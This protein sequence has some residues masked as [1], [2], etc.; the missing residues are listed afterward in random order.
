VRDG[1]AECLDHRGLTDAAFEVQDG[2]GK[3]APHG[4][5]NAIP[6]AEFVCRVFTRTEID[7]GN[8][9]DQIPPAKSAGILGLL[10]EAVERRSAG[11]SFTAKRRR[12]RPE[13]CR[14]GR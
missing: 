11:Q 7:P 12:D 4:C 2:N 6:Q 8:A 13:R 5:A 9:V 10:F 14:R 3:C 1:R